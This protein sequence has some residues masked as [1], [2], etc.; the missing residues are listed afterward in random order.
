MATVAIRGASA[1]FAVEVPSFIRRKGI[2]KRM[3]I[4]DIVWV[5]VV[6]VR[7]NQGAVF[8]LAWVFEGGLGKGVVDCEEVKVHTATL[9]D[10]QDGRVEASVVVWGHRR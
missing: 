9:A 4:E 2:V 3:Q 6:E 10:T 7:A 1:L 8:L 5:R